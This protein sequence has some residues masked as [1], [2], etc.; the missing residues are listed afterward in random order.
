VTLS[1]TTSIQGTVHCVQLNKF[2]Q[3]K[4]VC[5]YSVDHARTHARSKAV[6]CLWCVVNKSRW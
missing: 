1:W 3:Y 4:T 2:L 5:G 6:T